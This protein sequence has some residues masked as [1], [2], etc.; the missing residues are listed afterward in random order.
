M[1]GTCSALA[2]SKTKAARAFQSLPLS[3]FLPAVLDAPRL[4]ATESNRDLTALLL[5]KVAGQILPKWRLNRQCQAF[6]F[7]RK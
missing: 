7:F 2:L 4:A 5:R 3:L 1:V 6:R